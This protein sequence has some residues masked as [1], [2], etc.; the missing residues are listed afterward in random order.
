ML[1]TTPSEY[2]GKLAF[3]DY[4]VPTEP[5]VCGLQAPLGKSLPQGTT[6][7]KISDPT[8]DRER[9][10]GSQADHGTR[11]TTHSTLPRMRSE[12]PLSRHGVEDRKA[13]SKTMNGRSEFDSVENG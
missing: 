4:A 9:Q 11:R 8:S 2:L 7:R 6:R 5:L 10:A 3:S 12:A 13:T 1:N